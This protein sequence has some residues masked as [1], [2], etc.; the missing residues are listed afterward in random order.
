[1]THTPHQALLRAIYKVLRP[2]A[3]LLMR[4]GVSYKTF[5]DVARHVFVD[6]A[7]DDFAL[8][9][10]KPSNARTAVLTGIN[11]KDIAK[12]K[13]RPHPLSQAGSESPNPAARIITAWLND[14]LFHDEA[15]NPK[16]LLVEDQPLHP[17]SF[18]SLA[19]EYS[20]DVPV[21]AL[22]DELLR[23]AA[24]ERNGD[25]VTLVAHAYVPIAD[26]EENLRIFGTAAAD[27]L[28]TMDHN[29]GRETAG[30]F[31]QRT[32]SYNNV[33]PQDLE[34]IRRRCREEGE[35]LLLKVNDWLSEYEQ[36]QGSQPSTEHPFRTGLGVYYI[37]E[38]IPDEP[39][40]NKE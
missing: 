36:K 6:V 18:T 32:V 33:S 9:G 10:R 37:E 11:R 39:R 14:A 15:G 20:S 25:L 30:P 17:D 1:M 23:I 22:I 28:N 35:I 13:G 8:S 3:R 21:R 26:V 5:A 12:L 38:E 31:L 29:I 2:M 7:E 34:E 24:I 40:G 4:H 16:A 27:L 19:K